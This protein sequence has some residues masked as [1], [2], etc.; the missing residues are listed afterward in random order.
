MCF[1]HNILIKMVSENE[2]TTLENEIKHIFESGANEK[3]IYDLCLRFANR[4]LEFVIKTQPIK[5]CL[6][7]NKKRINS[8][9]IYTYR[10]ENCG[11][12][13]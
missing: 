9:S 7:L 8:T 10:C 4:Q 12:Y 13:L 11:Q 3:R 6:H 1:Y 5:E 2:K